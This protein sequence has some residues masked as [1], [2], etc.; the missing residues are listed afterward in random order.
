[1]ENIN[2]QYD[3][4]EF[5]E[6]NS[7]NDIPPY[8]FEFIPYISEIDTKSTVGTNGNNNQNSIPKVTLDNVKN[9]ISNVFFSSI[10]ENENVIYLYEL[11]NIKIQIS[12]K[13]LIQKYTMIYRKL[14]ITR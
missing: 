10:P 1:M 13:A 3:I 14:L 9:F 4:R 7:T 2:T 11:I 12:L 5:I 8:K 6:N